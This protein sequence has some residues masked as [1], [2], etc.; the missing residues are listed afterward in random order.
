MR[1]VSFIF[2]VFVLTAYLS[3]N[4]G[5]RFWIYF[6]DKGRIEIQKPGGGIT[7]APV[8]ERSIQ[9]RINQGK[10][11]LFDYSD[12]PLESAYLQ[13]IRAMGFTIHRQSKWL[14]AVTVQAT[15]AQVEELFRLPFVHKIEKVGSYHYSNQEPASDPDQSY[16]SRIRQSEYG[17]SE[18]QN[19]MIG[20]PQVHRMGY[21]GE[22][23]RI[24]LFDSGYLL[25]HE[26]LQQVQVVASRDFIQG[27]S[28]VANEGTDVSSQHNHGTQILAIIAG[29]KP[30]AIIGPAYAA[31]FLLAK[32]ELIN[33]ET[34][35]E[36]D[37]WVAAAEWA[38][39][40]GADIIATS[41]GYSVFDSGEVDYSYEDM[42]GNT[43]IITRAADLAASRGIA[44]FSA[45]GNE[46]SNSWY[47]I[48]APADGD[49]VIAIGGV[50]AN[51]SPWP[52]S[53]NGP[54]F[55]GRIK[56]DLVA[57]A[58]S[59]YSV[60]PN[61]TNQYTYIAGT[62]A[63]CPLAAGAAALLLSVDS[64]L[65]PMQ[66]RELM[67]TNASR[68]QNPDN[69][70]G[71]GLI[72]VEKSIAQILNGTIIKLNSFTA[73]AGPGRNVLNWT[74]D[75]RM[76]IK[77]WLIERQTAQSDFMEVGRLE[78][79]ADQEYPAVLNFVDLD[80]SGGEPCRYRL[81]A[82]LVAGDSFILDTLAVQSALPRQT[83]LYQNFPN[84]F[85]SATQI[86][87][88]LDRPQKIRLQIYD[89]NGKLA[90]TILDNRMLAAAFH[91]YIWDGAV[92]NGSL[93][94]SGIYYIVL[95]GESVHQVIKCIYLK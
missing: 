64:A 8:G 29:Y 56:P 88:S 15:A 46:G 27:D 73:F 5:Q 10:H 47:Y 81:R 72:N 85:N 21:H 40:M 78:M 33:S 91:H 22:G 66:L 17:P 95:S 36:E 1:I 70:L 28:I 52:A 86:I 6:K 14:N 44:V 38:D 3:A 53:S 94:A 57:Q 69:K 79:P 68:A 37:N 26:A 93:A 63:A 61:S 77:E 60:S 41:L 83:Q 49:S 31:E 82:E 20:I 23:V 87:F 51:G 16:S 59:V 76:A 65:T 25:L 9:R 75:S 48:T 11:P 55:D 12:L 45:A 71:Y 67:I 30:D 90:K 39:S 89:G 32:T 18:N 92:T 35:L 7:R 84:P 58:Q 19:E 4:P 43:A 74:A 54:T 42:D 34:H 80:I 50:R 24:A 2:A 62:S 13:K